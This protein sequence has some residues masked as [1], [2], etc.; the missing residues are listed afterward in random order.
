MKAQHRTAGKGSVPP[1]GFSDRSHFGLSQ[2]ET[3]CGFG[4][5]G[6]YQK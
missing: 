4:Q 1:D 2:A 5:P 6:Q 3:K